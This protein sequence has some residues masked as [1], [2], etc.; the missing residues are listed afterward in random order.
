M[1][2]AEFVAF[3][4][5]NPD[6]PLSSH[7]LFTAVA[8]PF[9]QRTVYNTCFH[10]IFFQVYKQ[11]ASKVT[12]PC[13]CVVLLSASFLCHRLQTGGHV[14]GQPETPVPTS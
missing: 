12:S 7:I 2:T 9:I 5:P 10:D 13:V 6:P 11:V 14:S 8:C 4:E 1:F 3:W